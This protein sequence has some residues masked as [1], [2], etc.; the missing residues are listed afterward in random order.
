MP[1]PRKPFRFPKITLPRV[2][3]GE[4]YFLGASA[5]VDFLI[6]PGR[7]ND[8]IPVN[9]TRLYMRVASLEY[10]RLGDGWGI[11]DRL[12]FGI[13]PLMF[14]PGDS[15]YGLD[16]NAGYRI[17]SAANGFFEDG[18]IWFSVIAGAGFTFFSDNGD[19]PFVPYA[20]VKA[21]LGPVYAAL[22]FSPVASAWF[23]ITTGLNAQ[24]RKN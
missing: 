1:P 3:W 4:D 18:W 8:S 20:Q 14:R 5:L 9:D 12:C 19:D 2:R 23:S 10:G 24:W 13:S 11:E 6:I 15:G 22:R 21:L 7:D 17:W 16:L